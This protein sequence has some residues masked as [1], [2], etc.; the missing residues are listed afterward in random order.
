[1]RRLVL[2]SLVLAGVCLPLASPPKAEAI[3]FLCS[4]Y[5]CSFTTATSTSKCT[6]N[7]VQTT[8]GWYWSQ[9]ACP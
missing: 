4:S 9:F 5:C 6:Y 1:M 8:C 3:V 2:L 7:G